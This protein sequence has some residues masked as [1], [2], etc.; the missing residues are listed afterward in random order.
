MA[1]V[2]EIPLSDEEAAVFTEVAQIANP[3][4]DVLEILY[5]AQAVAKNGLR[6]AVA[7]IRRDQ[8]REQQS[9][10]MASESAEFDDAWPVTPVPGDDD[11]DLE[12]PPDVVPV[13]R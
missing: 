12:N 13:V 1:V 3:D 5:W 2:V 8:I 4:A 9:V 6:R 10:E 11:D 7:Q